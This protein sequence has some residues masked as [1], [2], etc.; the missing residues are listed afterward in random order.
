VYLD[1]TGIADIDKTLIG[2]A[3]YDNCELLLAGQF[4]LNNW[5]QSEDAG[6]ISAS[7]AFIILES[8]DDYSGNAVET[9]LCITSQEEVDFEFSWEY[10]TLDSSPVWDPFGYSIDGIFNQLTPDTAGTD[11]FG[12]EHIRL[13]SGQY[14]CF[15]QSTTDAT[16][17]GARTE[18][19]GVWSDSEQFPKICPTIAVIQVQ[20]L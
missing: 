19:T 9:S 12:N 2:G 4:A 3:S 18:L 10:R 11:L 17:G 1:N 15:V 14:F 20:I 5:I 16:G 8:L 7:S 6:Q 13:Q